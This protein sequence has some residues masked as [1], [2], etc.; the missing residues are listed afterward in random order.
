ME[1]DVDSK[2]KKQ[3]HSLDFTKLN[4]AAQDRLASRYIETE[5]CNGYANVQIFYFFVLD[6]ISIFT[7]S[8]FQH[9]IQIRNPKGFRTNKVGYSAGPYIGVRKR[10]GFV[11]FSPPSRRLING[12]GL[13]ALL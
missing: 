8:G 10:Y 2:Q 1:R 12:W 7:F 4:K 13:E 11:Y 3:N 5:S 6:V 9:I